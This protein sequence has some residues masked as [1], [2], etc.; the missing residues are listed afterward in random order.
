MNRLKLSR[1]DRADICGMVILAGI[2]AL[3]TAIG[4]GSGI[5]GVIRTPVPP[6]LPLILASV[7]AVCLVGGVVRLHQ[8]AVGT[9]PFKD[10][11]FTRLDRW[12]EGPAGEEK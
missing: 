3:A 10:D 4:L 9:A 12:R 5:G 8:A 1:R 6:S 7:G 2:V 11:T